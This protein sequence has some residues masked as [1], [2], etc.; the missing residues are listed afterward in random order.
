M[1]RISL[2]AAVLP[3]VLPFALL[4]GAPVA[5]ASNANTI[6]LQATVASAGPKGDVIDLA[7][8]GQPFGTLKVKRCGIDSPTSYFCDGTA[9]VPGLISKAK[10][11]IDWKC[12]KNG[13]CA[14]KGNGTV[15][16]NGSTL[17]LVKLL[18]NPVKATKKGSTYTVKVQLVGE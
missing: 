15:I 10:V 5:D 14:N 2:L 9:T 3:A 11:A 1:R 16:S 8:G 17:A 4:T 6:T 7:Q 12:Q 18:A 13:P